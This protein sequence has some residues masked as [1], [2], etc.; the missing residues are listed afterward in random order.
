MTG[1]SFTSSTCI[2][3]PKTPVSI[4]TPSARR[5]AQNASKSGSASP[6]GAASEKLGRLPFVVSAISVN[7][8]TTRAAPSGVEKAPVELA[9]GVLEHAQPCDLLGQ[10][11][12][13]ALR[14]SRG[15]AE[16]DE[17]PGSGVRR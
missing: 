3:A 10:A 9:L 13:L 6:G 17:E 4:G 1:P 14:V 2:R 8:L 15:D 12:G 16:Q 7:W 11:L 5:A